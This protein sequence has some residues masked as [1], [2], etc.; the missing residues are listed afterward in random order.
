MLLASLLAT[1]AL[2]FGQ[3]P[4]L[5]TELNDDELLRRVPE[6]SG[7]HFDHDEALVRTVLLPALDAVNQTF[8]EFADLSA[9]E[10]I[11]ELRLENGGAR[12]RSQTENFRYVAT[13]AQDSLDLHELRLSAK[14]NKGAKA[15]KGGFV[16]GDRFIAMME[17][18]RP[19]FENQLRIRTIGRQGDQV[20]FAFVEGPGEGSSP[21]QGLVW[22]DAKRARPMRLLC[23]TTLT[24]EGAAAEQRRIDLM[25]ADVHFDALNAT[26]LLPARAVFDVS[27]GDVR[28]HAVHRFT[29]FHLY[30][31]DD[32]NDPQLAKRNAGVSTAAVAEH[33]AL[34]Q[35]GEGA[36]ALDANNAAGAVTLL[37]EALRLDATLAAAHYHLA[38]ALHATGDD[39]SA[40]TE[41]R[42][43][44][45]D[46]GSVPAA[47]N[48]LGILLMDRGATVEAVVELRE[49][50]RLAPGDATAHGNLSGALEAS[51]DRAGA[52]AELRRAIALAPANETFKARLNVLSGKPRSSRRT[53]TNR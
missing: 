5:L 52:L 35:L 10:Q 3:S 41:A 29:E 23:E 22:I 43:A 38:R 28:T 14:E 17:L 13:M 45:S 20:V 27:R 19:E 53:G 37:R 44:L 21:A 9:A 51:G 48:L 16:A 12:A 4:K 25:F 49:T 11:Y 6:L 42:A 7:V 31:R 18:L 24:Q 8:D 36:A 32:A 34:E 2:A 50:V 39:R 30:G 15:G 33:D 26:L 46:M 40:E 47:H 1:S